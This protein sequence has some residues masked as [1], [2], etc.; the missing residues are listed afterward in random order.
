MNAVE[1]GTANLYFIR[2]PYLDLFRLYF[3]FLNPSAADEVTAACPLIR[4]SGNVN[5][6]IGWSE[7]KNVLFLNSWVG[8]SLSN[9]L[10]HPC[11]C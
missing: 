3:F 4:L 7:F 2:L 10:M 6:Q 9:K 1:I 5:F 11:M 8:T